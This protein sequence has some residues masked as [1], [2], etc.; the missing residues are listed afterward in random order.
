MPPPH[1]H[2]QENSDYNS[3]APSYLLTPTQ[4]TYLGPALDI[5]Q[6]FQTG[7]KTLINLGC[8]SNLRI[9]LLL[10]SSQDKLH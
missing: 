10:A 1:L 7:H 6:M 3:V 8:H 9:P 5:S 4:T 2:V